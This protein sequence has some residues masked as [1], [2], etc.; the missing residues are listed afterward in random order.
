MTQ[1]GSGQDE[2][3]VVGAPTT[4]TLDPESVAVEPAPCRPKSYLP[5]WPFVL[6]LM[7]W[8]GM[9]AATVV[10]LTG[11]GAAAVPVDDPAYPVVLLVGLTLAACGPLL[12]LTVWIVARARAVPECRGGL[13][14]TALVR[15]AS[16]TLFGVVAWWAALLIVDALRLGM[17]R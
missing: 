16:A 6:Y 7:V 14:T 13:L 11:P 9:A 1:V 10:I 12:S 3:A 17:V 2:V 8:A 15:G 5:G 4:P